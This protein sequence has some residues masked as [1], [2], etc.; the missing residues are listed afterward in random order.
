[1]S[2]PNSD[3]SILFRAA[4]RD[5]KEKPVSREFKDTVSGKQLVNWYS[6]VFR[7]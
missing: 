6:V 2:R 3:T 5:I 1:M 7:G 4:R